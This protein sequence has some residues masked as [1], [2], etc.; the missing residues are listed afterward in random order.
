VSKAQL[1][2]D[3][4]SAARLR[5]AV[6]RLMRRLRRSYVSG[7][8]PTQLSALASI[9]K[10]QPVRL[11]DL[12]GYEGISPSTL[13]PIVGSLVTGGYVERHTDPDDARSALVAMT[14]QGHQLLE[15]LRNE[16]ARV[17]QERLDSLSD[18]ERAAL[19]AAITLLE[20]L[21]ED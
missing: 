21:A 15:Q 10:L 14:G 17:L 2:D 1:A 5:L 6:A 9:E 12:A 20:R 8:T 7:L 18:Q 3:V 11:G 16:A 4:D 13:S 19:D